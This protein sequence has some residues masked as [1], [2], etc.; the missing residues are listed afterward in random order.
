MVFLILSASQSVTPESRV[1]V[2]MWTRDQRKE[3]RVGLNPISTSLCSVCRRK[4]EE[5]PEVQGLTTAH[6]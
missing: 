6:F 2:D 1:S 4:G 3:G 5:D